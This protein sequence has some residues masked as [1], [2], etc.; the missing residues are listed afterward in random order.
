MRNLWRDVLARLA[1]YDSGRPLDA[2]AAELGLPGITR[3]SANE[4]PLGPSPR[5][6]QAI[7]DA[8]RSVHLYPD[9]AS[10]AVRDA[11]GHRLGVAPEQIVLGN[12]ADELLNMIAW[13]AFEPGDEVVVPQPSFEPYTTMVTLMG[14]T[15]VA[16]P[17]RHYETDLD[18][19]AARLTRRTK[20]ILLC[21]PHNPATTIIRRGPL[22]ALLDALGPEGPLVVLDEAYRDFCDDPDY[23]D[24]V[25][26]L[27]RY[28]RLLVLRTFSKIAALAGLRVGY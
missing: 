13:A 17:L 16:S 25:A 14:A 9:G 11:L 3:L 15:L 21:S 22:E 27:T 23:P 10:V 12:G 7:A 4:N 6:I 8:A 5:V 19:V 26:L 24:G 28:P 1:P 20:A 2:L 18:D